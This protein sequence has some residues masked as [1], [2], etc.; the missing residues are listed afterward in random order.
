MHRLTNMERKLV[1]TPSKQKAEHSS[2]EQPSKG[3]CVQDHAV[4][5]TQPKDP[6]SH[7]QVELR[8][9]S[10]RARSKIA[11]HVVAKKSELTD[12][13]LRC[14]VATLNSMAYAYCTTSSSKRAVTLAGQ[15]YRELCLMFVQMS[16]APKSYEE[17]RMLFE[18][19]DCL[20][21]RRTRARHA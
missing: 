2:T 3:C 10:R 18:R 17:A 1:D 11:L 7:W 14:K 16:Q 19:V 9:Y 4:T 21:T 20:L 5:S 13:Q 6:K 8:K 15:L 12:P